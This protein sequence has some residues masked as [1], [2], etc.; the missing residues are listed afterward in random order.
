MSSDSQVTGAVANSRKREGEPTRTSTGVQR[1]PVSPSTISTIGNRTTW[2]NNLLQTVKGDPGP[3]L[4]GS[5]ANL[6]QGVGTPPQLQSP[7]TPATPPTPAGIVLPPPTTTPQSKGDSKQGQGGII[8]PTPQ[9]PS[10]PSDQP[11][12]GT[13]RTPQEN[14]SRSNPQEPEPTPVSLDNTNTGS[15]QF[16][17]LGVAN[18]HEGMDP[19]INAQGIAD[20][21]TRQKV[22]QLVPQIRSKLR[23]VHNVLSG[24]YAKNE[25][26]TPPSEVIA[27]MRAYRE[28]REQKVWRK[29]DFDPATV[30][31]VNKLWAIFGYEAPKDDQGRVVFDQ[32]SVALTDYLTGNFAGANDVMV[33]IMLRERGGKSVPADSSL[34]ALTT[35]V[36]PYESTSRPLTAAI[37]AKKTD[38]DL[39]I[40]GFLRSIRINKVNF[41]ASAH[42]DL[43]SETLVQLAENTNTPEKDKALTAANTQF[44]VERSTF[45]S[46]SKEL[47]NQDPD[48]L[49]D[50]ILDLYIPFIGS[51][52][53]EAGGTATRFNLTSNLADLGEPTAYE[54]V[55]APSSGPATSGTLPVALQT[56]LNNRTHESLLLWDLKIAVDTFEWR[57]STDKMYG[58][59]YEYF[60][61][62]FLTHKSAYSK[63]ATQ[64]AAK[65]DKTPRI[66]NAFD[67]AMPPG[68]DIVTQG[69]CLVLSADRHS[70]RRGGNKGYGNHIILFYPDPND[71][72][73]QSGIVVFHGHLQNVNPHLIEQLKSNNGKPIPVKAGTTVAKIGST[74]QSTGPHDHT[75][76]FVIKNGRFVKRADS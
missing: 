2:R 49:D 3:S 43:L 63:K 66:D 62:T 56:I 45:E 12:A 71:Q 59:P 11:R 20:G 44:A 35:I 13:P 54:T 51:G 23:E 67:I 17:R 29:T 68:T 15:L 34:K 24:Y 37:N 69:D 7:P 47:F 27:F 28:M 46:K 6:D 9:P 39:P 21:P 61:K 1:A 53:G 22:A 76:A 52:G 60:Q 14:A 48:P 26:M 30:E 72:T 73:G 42:L 57:D 50:D 10:P 65:R 36:I 74:G 41:G 75:C 32:T 5:L 64:V 58:S 33:S 38:D 19:A 70:P 31:V 55:S 18:V 16:I 40:S 25:M 4:T 8:L